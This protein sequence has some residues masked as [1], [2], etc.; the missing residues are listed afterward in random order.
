MCLTP[1]YIMPCANADLGVLA[2]ILKFVTIHLNMKTFH[3]KYS[4]RFN[5]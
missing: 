4:D 2:Y 5:G 3:L 1:K